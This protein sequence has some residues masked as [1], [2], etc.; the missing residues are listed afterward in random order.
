[1]TLNTDL[2]SWLATRPD[3]QKDAVSRFCRS[4]M[5]ST[6]DIGE[7]ADKLAAGTYPTAANVRAEDIPGSTAGGDAVNLV[8]VADVRGVNALIEGQTLSFGSAGMTIVFGNNAS[9]KS[10][11]ARLIRQAVTARVKSEHLLGDVFAENATS[12]AAKLNY[13][14]GADPKDWNLGEPQI[15]DLSRVRFYD[16]DCGDAYVTAA[17]E[18]NYRP[19]ALR[20]LDQLSDA[21][22]A[23]AAELTRRLG[24]NQAERPQLPV[25]HPGTAASTFMSGLSATTST[26]AIA[27]ST[28]LTADHDAQLG[29]LLTEEARLKGSDPNKEKRRLSALSH[30]WSTIEAHLKSLEAALGSGPLRTLRELQDRAAQLREAARIASANTFDSESLASVGSETWRALWESAREFS[31]TDGYHEHDYPYTENGAVCVLCQQPL[32][33]QGANRLARFEAFVTDTTSRDADSAADSL[34]RRRI[35]L[36]ELQ[37]QPLSVIAAMNR[38]KDGGEE[39]QATLDW[40]ESATRIAESAVGWLDGAENVHPSPLADSNCALAAARAQAL[41]AQ[42]SAIDAST[43][44]LTLSTTSKQVVEFQDA[45]MLCEAKVAI[46]TE[47]ARLAQRKKIEDVRRLTAT[48]ALTTKRG[49]LTETYVTA[50]VRDRFTRETE[51]L[52]L[53]RITLNR[54]GRGRNS[55]LAHQPS[56]LGSHRNAGIDEVLSEGEQTALGL[57]GF[58]TEVELDASLS[59]VVF[60]DPVSSLDAGRRSKVAQRLAEL[61]GQRQVI[62][63][64]HEITFVHA[65]N[66]AAKRMSVDVTS[67]SIQRMGGTQPGLVVDQL[68]WAARDIPLRIDKLQVDLAQLRRERLALTAD[69]Y[70]ER[71]ARIA[72]QLSETLERALNLHIV[73][74]L[75]DRGTNEVRPTMLKILPKFTQADHDEFQATYAKTSS[76]AARH[77]NAPEENYEPPTV[78]EIGEEITWLKGWHSRVK[79]YS[80]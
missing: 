42:A 36:A 13:L 32:S 52:E 7:I 18:V 30:D 29:K 20:I 35:A 19:S 34:A 26:E 45:K 51:R 73:N 41:T 49:E 74:E 21:C 15:T 72:G 17:S 28:T 6:E 1:M 47:V 9:G 78:D 33:E 14:T 79:R 56:L 80:S 23:V 58:L 40:L 46:Q 60:D 24:T 2:A 70:A 44:A 71:T 77:D 69:N 39:V 4:E 25:L 65:L 64:T 3:W 66:Q 68:P 16:E 55:A 75:V 12:P 50:E 67:R 54:T 53:R 57:A 63:F 5:L 37:A 38:L 61:A 22:E 43:F 62:V 76:W 48:N 10:G 27:S 11:Y 8:G 59:S 31:L